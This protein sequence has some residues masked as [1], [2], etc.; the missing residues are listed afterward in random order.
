MTATPLLALDI[1]CHILPGMDDGPADLT[2]SIALAHRLVAAGINHVVATSHI[3]AGLYPNN[4]RRLLARTQML[5]G[6]LRAL[7][8][9]LRLVP[10]AEVRLDPESC[11]PESW[12]T[13]GDAARYMLVELPPGPLVIEGIEAMLRGIQAHGIRPVLAHPERAVSL[14]KDPG[15]LAAWVQGGVLAQGT[16]SVL[17]GAAGARTIETLERFLADGLIHFVATDAHHPDRRLADL[18]KA[19]RRLEA[20]VGVE[21]AK[22]LRFENPAALLLGAPVAPPQPAVDA[23][24]T[25]LMTATS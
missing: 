13:I 8:V 20:V 14:Q 17:A 10:G 11:R 12:L 16:L 21:A 15:L 22:R 24:T 2:A 3:T 19:V 23:P 1:H 7:G 5:A 4:R 9:P 6:T 18:E 25:R